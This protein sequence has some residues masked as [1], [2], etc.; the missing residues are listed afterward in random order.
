MSQNP[1]Q[2]VIN[3]AEP[4]F[5]RQLQWIREN[6]PS[7]WNSA[8]AGEQT[9]ALQDWNLFQNQVLQQG[10]QTQLGALNAA[11][12]FGLG[13][14]GQDLQMLMAALTAGG[15]FSGPAIT[16]D[17]GFFGSLIQAGGTV[18]GAAPW[19][20][21]GGGGNNNAAPSGPYATGSWG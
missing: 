20:W 17:P 2:Q 18:A 7:R 10:L 9:R 3:A 6:A 19:N 4:G 14:S 15:A 5:Q 11:G 1:G 13:T 16:Q 12:Q 21:F 8:V